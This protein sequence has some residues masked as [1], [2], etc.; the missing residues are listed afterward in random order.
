[1]KWNQLIELREKRQLTQKEIAHFIGVPKNTYS[2]WELGLA[3]PKFED[4]LS[5]ADFFGV[6]TD[7]LLGHESRSMITITRE[8][9]Q[10]LVK[11]KGVIDR[12]LAKAHSQFSEW[13]GND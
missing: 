12:L 10:Q 13:N 7:F 6:T 2:N 8:D 1:M 3:R 5:L 11:A 9:Y 4:L